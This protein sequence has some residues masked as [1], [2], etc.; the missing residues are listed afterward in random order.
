[1]RVLVTPDYRSLSRQ[2]AQVVVEA[3]AVKPDLVLLLPTGHTPL[4]MYQELVR[5]HREEGVRFSAIRTFNL[6]E[7]LGLSPAHP[8]SYHAYMRTQFFDHVDV[9]QSN[10][11]IPN[12]GPGV[13]TDKECERYE[14]AIRAAG[15]VDLLIVG[16]GTNGHIAFNEP[17]SSFTS[18]TRVVT[19]AAETVANARQYFTS[20]AEVPR[21]AITVGIGT[22][23]EARRIVLLASGAGKAEAV[24][25]ALQG[26]VS[27]SLPASAL[28][29]HSN[30]MAILDKAAAPEFLG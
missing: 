18:R 23:L 20:D 24:K 17:A 13:D 2:A 6:D 26:P 14:N 8:R 9:P 29:L 22:I 3:L 11:D 10:I 15:G 19:L 1:M 12:G 25:R 30:V 28:Q 16:V 27:E 4:G 7:Y 21:R 5:R